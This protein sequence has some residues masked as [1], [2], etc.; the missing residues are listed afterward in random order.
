MTRPSMAPKLGLSG[1]SLCHDCLYQ[2][3]KIVETR[4]NSSARV[5]P[6]EG[7]YLAAPGI[8]ALC[9]RPPKNPEEI[10]ANPAIEQELYGVF[11]YCT[12]CCAELA[13]FINYVSPKSVEAD[14]TANRLLRERVQFLSE[15]VDY[16][17]G[18]LNARISAAGSGQPISDGTFGLPVSEVESNSDFVDR[19][20]DGLE[21]DVNQSG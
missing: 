18:L 20:I 6:T 13:S 5:Q 12:E 21:S 10:F 2:R 3:V 17:R 9:G 7:K 1:A 11:Y 8:C 14:K 4:V 19:V 16:L 15:Q